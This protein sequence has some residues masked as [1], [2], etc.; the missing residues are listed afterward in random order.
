[1]FLTKADLEKQM[2]AFGTGK[3]HHLD[4]FRVA[5]AE[6]NTAQKN[7]EYALNFNLFGAFKTVIVDEVRSALQALVHTYSS[8]TPGTGKR[9]PMLVLVSAQHARSSRY[10]LH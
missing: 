1:V 5:I 10:L 4:E 8:S 3:E 9:S 2:K 6:Q 7:K